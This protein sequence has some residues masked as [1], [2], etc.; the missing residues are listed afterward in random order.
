MGIAMLSLGL[1]C[2]MVALAPGSNGFGAD[3]APAKRVL[4]LA[5]GSRFSPG[6]PILEQS[7]TDQLRKLQGEEIELYS[8][9]LDIV[10]FPSASYR[11][12][13]RDYLRRKYIDDVPDLIV[14]SFV[15]NLTVTQELLRD[16]FPST[17]VIAVGLSEE[18]FPSA[19]MSRG[20]TGLVQRSDPVGTI[21]LILRLQPEIQR[22]VLIGGVADVDRQVMARATRAARSF[23]ARLAIEVWSNRSMGEILKA[24]GALPP[25]TAI[26]FTRMFR[27]GDGRAVNS[28][29]AAQ[30]I[31]MVANVPFYGMTD[32]MF[33]T[34]A[35]GGAA[36]DLVALGRRAGELAH[37][38]LS[39]ADSQ[40]IPLQII[41]R[42]APIFDWRALK[43]WGI[44]ESRLPK[45][46]IV[47]FRPV[48]I[49]QEYQWLIIFAIALFM[50][51]AILI[52]IL[53]REK[54]RRR[55]T[56]FALDK[57]LRFEKL[58]AELSSTFIN[59][60][61]DKVEAQIVEALG[62]VGNLLGFDVVALS[63]FT[64]AEGAGRVA[65]I[66]KRAGVPDI[67]PDLSELDFPWVAQRLFT[68][69]DVCFRHLDELPSDAKIDRAT[70]ERWQIRSAYNVPVSAGGAV[71]GV[72]GLCTVW[73]NR[74]VSEE[75]L[76]WERLLAEIFANALARKNSEE[77]RQQSEGSFRLLVESTAAVPWQAD[78]N[79]WA[80]TYVG[81]QA[82]ALLGFP[83]ADWYDKEFWLSHVHPDDRE[84][85]TD[86]RAAF[87][88]ALE[89][90]ELEYRMM[91]A[92]G[93]I[94]WLHDFIR[95]EYQE[96]KP[97]RLRGFLL[98]V[99]K[100]KQAEQALEQE[101]AFLRQVIDIDPNFIFAKDREGRF[102]LANRALADAYGTSVENLIGKTDANFNSNMDEVG[103]FNQIDRE[104]IDTLQE[105]FIPEEYITDAQG[106]IRWLQTVKRPIIG[107]N[108]AA[109][110]VLGAAS[111]ITQRKSAEADMQR[112]RDELAHI[113]RV[114]TMGELAASLAHELNQPLTAILS[115]AQAAQRFLAAQPAEL[116]EV[117]EI[118][119]DIVQ[120]NNRASQVIQRMRALV[121][122]ESIA[123][124]PLDLP[125]FIKDVVQLLNSDAVL[126]NVRV[127]VEI[128][129]D[130]P[131]VHGDKVQLQ[132]VMLNL[133]LNAFDAMTH[134]PINERMVAVLA[135]RD[136]AERMAVAVRDHGTGLA[137]DKLAKIFQPFYTTK[138]AGLG[139]GL[140]I[141]RSI[142][143]AHGGRLWAENNSGRGATFFFTLSV[144][145]EHEGGALGKMAGG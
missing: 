40:S 135:Q 128:D 39:G 95:C 58:V 61:F 47:R 100:R 29:Q 65:H 69:H 122:K 19:G 62:R 26:L 55:L 50:I 126:H 96:G 108:G 12:F 113:A 18:A 54:H 127:S 93:E 142:V 4:M 38:I 2:V 37:R 97:A 101:R 7:V 35:V 84:R 67:P 138:P 22:L 134:C 49:W 76:E 34:G 119:K 106:K 98:D 79:P 59:L 145:L 66:W 16:L 43:R 75:L 144:A 123:F 116:D 92:S 136:G 94:V 103:F 78:V 141:S 82:E 89:Q 73:Q 130:L 107:A 41:S 131:P 115:N 5:T 1:V 121:K 105:R 102:T 20:L 68:G 140:S 99:S 88:Q 33:G 21:E 13:F 90:F 60:P 87:T 114:S 85:V 28:A 117:S 83:L 125:S 17:P 137:G 124:A 31:A 24:V 129:P 64:S 6:F 81:P 10:R 44:S 72:L 48:S 8:E 91:R 71:L 51:E 111:D 14:L 132:Q 70:Y 15:G 104:V 3:R 109:N 56:Q 30:D 57:R 118:L 23:A 77:L 63:V 112:L 32:V 53:L 143:E 11:G 36:V 42:G 52:G 45:D 80:L 27:D 25:R 46:S 9:Y 139:M 133:L 120:D 86:A 74:E 110:Q